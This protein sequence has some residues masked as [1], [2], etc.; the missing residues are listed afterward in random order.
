LLSD[1]DTQAVIAGESLVNDENNDNRVA[2]KTISNGIANKLS[3]LSKKYGVTANTVI[4]AAWGILL[5]RCNNTTDVVFGKV[6]SGRNIDIADIENAMG[7]FVNTIP[8]RVYTEMNDTVSDLLYSL[9]KQAYDSS[10][11]EICS[12]ADIQKNSIL[13]NELIHSLLVFENYY[14]HDSKTESVNDLNLTEIS[15]R[16]QTNYPITLNVVLNDELDLY[17]SYNALYTQMEI[18]RLLNVLELIINGIVDSPNTIINELN[19]VPSNELE[20]VIN[21]FNN[22]VEKYPE[23]STL[24]DIFE[25]RVRNQHDEIAI[26]FK[27]IALT[28]SQLNEKANFLGYQLRNSGVGPG[29]IVGIISYRSIEMIVGIYGVL[30]SGAAYMPIDPENPTE[31]IGHIIADSNAKVIL[32][33]NKEIAKRLE[34]LSFNCIILDEV[35]GS[36]NANLDKVSSWHDIAYVLYTSG[37]TGKPKGAMIEHK[38][39]VN[40]LYWMQKE[41]C[42]DKGDAVLQKTPYTFDVSVVEMFWWTFFGGKLIVALPEAEKDP[43]E[44]TR[45]IIDENISYVHFVPSMLSV[46]LDYI[47]R[48]EFYG[49]LRSLKVVVA[50]G[51]AL[52]INSAIQ[53]LGTLYKLN[54]TKL[55]NFYGPTEAAV[56]VSYFECNTEELQ[57]YKTVPIGK[58]ISN[59]QLY[60]LNDKLKPQPIGM[61]GELFISGDNVGRG[62][63]NMPDANE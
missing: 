8:V 57:Q 40:R 3:N 56:D 36:I 23:T 51:E 37:S 22:T 58:P 33:Q 5:Q 55:Y 17:L 26:K 35:E 11:N 27:D 50:S 53:F 28:Y 49:K 45:L 59:T 31:R 24:I 1:Y 54:R 16:E 19:I 6:V 43:Q 39:I 48:G 47:I 60:V 29:D 13:G 18:N 30:K 9:Q 38:S 15:F 52:S 44:I 62:Y 61:P 21:E 14:V 41:L 10:N 7:I 46:F 32:V 63:V 34:S 12:L 20:M 2:V 25:D 4:E 42:M